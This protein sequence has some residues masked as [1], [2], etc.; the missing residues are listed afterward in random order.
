MIHHDTQS[1]LLAVICNHWFI[2]F[3]K[4]VI[5]AQRLQKQ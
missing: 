5:L 2:R 1:E 4:L 3:F